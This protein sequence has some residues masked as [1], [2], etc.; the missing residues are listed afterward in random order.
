MTLIVLVNSFASLLCVRYQK[1]KWISLWGALWEWLTRTSKS[2]CDLPRGYM[3]SWGTARDFTDPRVCVCD[4]EPLECDTSLSC[5]ATLMHTRH[6]HAQRLNSSSPLVGYRYTHHSSLDAIIS[7]QTERERAA[8]LR[9]T[10]IRVC[11]SLSK[12]HFLHFIVD[13]IIFF[14]PRNRERDSFPLWQKK[15]GSRA[16]VCVYNCEKIKRK[17]TFISISL[18][19]IFYYKVL[20]RSI[21][22]MTL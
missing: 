15:K 8:T 20:Q 12:H 14:T 4:D 2:A 1:W 11:V 22:I 13:I 19:Q 3:Y 5:F 16:R 18:G 10:F 7:A 21:F 17:G 9:E 6:R